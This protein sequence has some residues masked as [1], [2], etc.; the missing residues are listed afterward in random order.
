MLHRKSFS[1]GDNRII[2]AIRLGNAN[3]L[4]FSD[5]GFWEREGIGSESWIAY[6]L[7]GLWGDRDDDVHLIASEGIF[8]DSNVTSFKAEMVAAESAI[9]FLHTLTS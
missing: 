1:Y 3:I 8:L 7:G 9:S 5:G 6:A 4:V 2:E